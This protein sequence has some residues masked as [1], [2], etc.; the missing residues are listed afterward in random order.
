MN[1]YNKLG[2]YIAYGLII[3]SVIGMV[4]DMYEIAVFGAAGLGIVFMPAVG[5]LLGVVIG[6]L[7]NNN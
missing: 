6:A 5:L 2:L 7:S 4:L 3:G 1:K